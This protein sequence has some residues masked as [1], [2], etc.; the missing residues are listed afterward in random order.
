MQFNNI[1]VIKDMI[2]LCVLPV[3]NARTPDSRELEFFGQLPV[4]GCGKVH[5]S[6]A[7]RKCERIGH[8]GGLA[9]RLGIY[10]DYP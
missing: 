10:A 3:I 1:F 5:N 9:R 4:N 2:Q 7:N 8:V 6:R